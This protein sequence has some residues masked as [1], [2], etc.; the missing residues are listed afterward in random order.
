MR[1]NI[2][3]DATKERIYVPEAAQIDFHKSDATW[4]AYF[5]GFG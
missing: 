3:T 4:R 2:Y 5:G 1:L